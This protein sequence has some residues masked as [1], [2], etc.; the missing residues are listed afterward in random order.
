MLRSAGEVRGFIEMIFVQLDDMVGDSVSSQVY[1]GLE[2]KQRSFNGPAYLDQIEKNAIYLAE[3]SRALG[4]AIAHY[5]CVGEPLLPP[6]HVGHFVFTTA[7]IQAQHATLLH[8]NYL[9]TGVCSGCQVHSEHHRY[10]EW[11]D[12]RQ[13]GDWSKYTEEMEFSYV[14]NQ[15]LFITGKTL[16]TA[17]LLNH[18]AAGVA[19]WVP[20]AEVLG[21]VR[22][23]IE[24]HSNLWSMKV[25]LD[26]PG[27]REQD[28][29]QASAGLVDMDL[30][31]SVSM[32]GQLRTKS[33]WER[34][35]FRKVAKAA[36][37]T[38]VV[39]EHISRGFELIAQ[40]QLK[41]AAT[42]FQ[43]ALHIDR[44]S[45]IAHGGLGLIY[46]QQG[47]LRK[48]ISQFKAALSLDPRLASAHNSL[49][50]VYVQQGRLEQA[51][52]EFQAALNINPND[53]DFHYQLGSTYEL[54]GRTSDAEREYQA[55]LCLNPE[56]P[57]AH[58]RIGIIYTS[59][60]RWHEAVHEWQAELRVNPS[61]AETHVLLAVGYR[62]LGWLE[63]AKREFQ[64]AEQAGLRPPH[65]WSDSVE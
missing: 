22:E 42:E 25:N 17:L 27:L 47:Q 37:D 63:E 18:Q 50:L 38:K 2:D 40:D 32:P 21:V 28:S 43:T 1:E 53:P 7:T 51:I 60:E 52:A 12:L 61:A 59:R 6:E 10:S 58:C 16:L 41:A 30:E 57:G 49:G 64:R 23:R 54:L 31:R 14:F 29:E 46:R 55:A 11:R 45:A 19:R 5:L 26:V 44:N 8:A 15:S 56:Y 9:R 36:E 65:G 4:A 3:G 20:P 35:G 34:L 24:V 48:A 39:E 33:L 62:K 13:S